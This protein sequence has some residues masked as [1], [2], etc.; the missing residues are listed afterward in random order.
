MCIQSQIL[1][2]SVH[3]IILYLDSIRRVESETAVLDAKLELCSIFIEYN[4]DLRVSFA[5]SAATNTHKN[6]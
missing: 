2:V 4:F 6:F 5:R 1:N 3:S